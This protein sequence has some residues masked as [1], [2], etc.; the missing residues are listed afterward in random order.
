LTLDDNNPGAHGE[1]RRTPVAVSGVVRAAHPV[2]RTPWGLLLFRVP[3]PVARRL[4]SAVWPGL[5]NGYR[6][7]PGNL[8]LEKVFPGGCTRNARGWL[9]LR[10]PLFSECGERPPRHVRTPRYIDLIKKGAKWAI[11]GRGFFNPGGEPHSGRSRAAVARRVRTPRYIRSARQPGKGGQAAGRRNYF[12]FSSGAR[13][14]KITWPV[15]RHGSCSAPWAAS[16]RLVF[17]A[18]FSSL[19]EY[20]S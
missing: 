6:P 3:K 7:P 18:R 13:A 8:A 12:G 9:E 11:S 17:R 14:I 4:T 15:A 1:R 10:V 16:L 19:R 20:S 5:I 2:T